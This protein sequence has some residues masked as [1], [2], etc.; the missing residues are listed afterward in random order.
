[1]ERSRSTPWRLLSWRTVRWMV[2]G[3][4]LFGALVLF[5][6]TGWFA[7][8]GAAPTGERL[9]RIRLSRNFRD[10]TFRNLVD[11]RLAVPGSTRRM[12][13]RQ[14]TGDE[15][16]VPPA[17]LPVVQLTGGEYATPPASGLR[18]TW[19]GHATVLVEIDGQ[20]VL[21]DPIW[22]AYA[23]PSQL[24]GPRRFFPPPLPL[25]A[26]PSI[27][28]VVVSHDHYDHLDMATVQALASAPRQAALRF[29]VPLGIGAH[30]ERWGVPRQRIA[31]L[32]W[33]DSAGVGGLTVTAM[34]A[35]HFSGR[36][37][38]G[39]NRTLWA[40][41]VITG[42]GHR[43]FH[44]GDTGFFDG[45]ATI[46]E[47]FGPFDLAMIKVGSY[48]EMWPDIHVNPEEAVR[49]HGML[50]SRLLLPIHWGTFNMAF[51]DWFEPADRVLAAARASG[52]AL[53]MPRPGE[54]VEP[55]TP[56]PVET[57]WRLGRD[58]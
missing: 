7:S 19:L 23:S 46:G 45:F 27:D 28:A 53:V 51:H 34:P 13:V 52:T 37:I 10:G 31:E 44:S 15:E 24:V 26:L 8:L 5:A 56:L 32:D 11:A 48:D 35:R 55:A 14:F 39:G 29:I 49:A 30:L 47:R 18:A 41:W 40:T 9:A 58:E 22:S 1:M 12:L 43:I 25:E 54:R 4:L 38:T 50:R 17:P 33:E 42:P 2:G 3:V 36:W 20:R 21:F 57:W 16:R 6:S